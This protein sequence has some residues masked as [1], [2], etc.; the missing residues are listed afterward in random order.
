MITTNFKNLLAENLK[1]EDFKN[2]FD[3]LEEEFEVSKNIIQL[4]INA[5]ITQKELAHLAHTSH[6]AIS[7]LES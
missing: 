6:A 2:K 5:G 7:R 4:R 3:T 1:D